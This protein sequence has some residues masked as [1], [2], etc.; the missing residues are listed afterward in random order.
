MRRYVFQLADQSNVVGNNVGCEMKT[1]AFTPYQY[2]CMPATNFQRMKDGLELHVVPSEYREN[3][4]KYFNKKIR[5][6]ENLIIEARK[7]PVF[8]Y[9][10]KPIKNTESYSSV[11]IAQIYEI[12]REPK[13]F[14]EQTD[15]I[16]S[17]SD[18]TEQSQYKATQFDY[19]TF[20]GIFSSR[21]NDNMIAHSGLIAIDFDHVPSVGA[22]RSQLL[23]D[24]LIDVDL[25]F[26]SPRGNGLKLVTSIDLSKGTHAQYFYSFRKYFFQNYAVAI[27]ESGKDVSRACFLCHDAEV[28]IHLKH[29]I[30]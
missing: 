19:V 9:Y 13:Y 11:T 28:F 27:D 7:E 2:Q 21:G 3:Y 30:K 12:I 1:E 18:K 17:L 14:K 4:D 22:L 8:S 29:R 26:M 10:K 6:D 15:F 25:L 16:R 5:P 24:V 23:A 20:S